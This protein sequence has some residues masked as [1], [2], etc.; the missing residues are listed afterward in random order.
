MATDNGEQVEGG[1]DTNRGT[2]ENDGLI[3]A[4]DTI[5]SA[6]APFNP[7]AQT[8]NHIQPQVTSPELVPTAQTIQTPNDANNGNGNGNN[9]KDWRQGWWWKILIILAVIFFMCLFF[10]WIGPTY[11]WGNAATN[12]SDSTTGGSSI[13]SPSPTLTPTDYPTMEPTLSPQTQIPTMSPILPTTAMPS[14]FPSN[15]PTNRPTPQPTFCPSE[16]GVYEEIGTCTISDRTVESCDYV[17][18]GSQF[19]YDMDTNGCST[20][21]TCQD[22]SACFNSTHYSEGNS[23]YPGVY[24]TY[25]I[26]D[27]VSCTVIRECSDA[28]CTTCSKANR[29]GNDIYIIL[30]LVIMTFFV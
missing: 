2:P 9:K 5:P 14:R 27:I 30:A 15:N 16:Q 24:S 10:I 20:T 17:E 7:E 22:S 1:V 13:I 8:Q 6:S 11:I 29:Y 12:S 25:D 26:G 23:V 28:S 19:E 21:I 4:Q 18:S 3:A